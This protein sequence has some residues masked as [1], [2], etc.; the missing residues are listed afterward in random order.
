MY[1]SVGSLRHLQACRDLLT[2]SRGGSPRIQSCLAFLRFWYL[3]ISGDF[4]FGGRYRHSPAD[5]QELGYDPL[6]DMR[7]FHRS[8]W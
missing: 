1:P 8:G 6:L 2:P 5:K 3:E 4:P 7:A